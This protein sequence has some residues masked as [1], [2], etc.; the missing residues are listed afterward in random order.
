M[1]EKNNFYDLMLHVPI[2]SSSLSNSLSSVN[3]RQN[4][5]GK[6]TSW[7]CLSRFLCYHI[8]LSLSR[9]FTSFDHQQPPQLKKAKALTGLTVKIIKSVKSRKNFFSIFFNMEETKKEISTK[10]PRCRLILIKQKFRNNYEIVGLFLLITALKYKRFAN[11]GEPA[12]VVG[13]NLQRMS[14]ILL[15]PKSTAAG[16]LFCNLQLEQRMMLRVGTRPVFVYVR[17]KFEN[18]YDIIFLS[19]LITALKFDRFPNSGEPAAVV[20]LLSQS[21]AC[22]S[23]L[24]KSAA[25]GL[26]FGWPMGRG[27][28]D[29]GI[30]EWLLGNFLIANCQVLIK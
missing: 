2:A 30:R 15:L 20:D 24:P 6:P 1:F 18:T 13:F 25:A 9:S 11:S 4:Y 16:L 8:P 23:A 28:I 22:D 3:T 29:R 17:M 12:A 5:H 26:L 27:L 19:L 14:N 10:P 21:L 7:F